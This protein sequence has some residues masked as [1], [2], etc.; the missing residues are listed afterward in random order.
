MLM[1]FRAENKLQAARFHFARRPLHTTSALHSSNY[2]RLFQIVGEHTMRRSVGNEYYYPRCPP[3]SALD[4]SSAAMARDLTCASDL[5]SLAWRRMNKH[6]RTCADNCARAWNTPRA[7]A[8][9]GWTHRIIIISHRPASSCS[10]TFALWCILLMHSTGQFLLRRAAAARC[11]ITSQWL[12][13]SRSKCLVRVRVRHH[14]EVSGT[15][16]LLRRSERL[17]ISLA[18]HFVIYFEFFIIES[19]RS[20]AAILSR[21]F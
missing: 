8:L 4:D 1:W 19:V 15:S 9:C 10:F 7:Y 12:R 16:L 21:W 20:L 3:C 2:W 14:W 17:V 11:I 13:K 18:Q 5:L 6:G